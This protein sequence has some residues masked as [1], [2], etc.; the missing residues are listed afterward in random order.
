MLKEINE[1]ILPNFGRI[2][3]FE[4]AFGARVELGQITGIP[5]QP[6]CH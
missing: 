1:L 6:Q 4:F 2:V 3:K 5:Y